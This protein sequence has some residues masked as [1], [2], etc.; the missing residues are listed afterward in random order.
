MVRGL[1]AMWGLAA[2][3]GPIELA[4]SELV[5][6]AIMHG[7]GL[8]DVRLAVAGDLIRLE[9]AD[10]GGGPSAPRRSRR[11]P[12]EFAGGWGLDLVERLSD[13]WGH[14]RDGGRT[15]VWMERRTGASLPGG[16]RA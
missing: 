3:Q 15:R 1:L 4:V 5:T 12:S 13:A 7:C 9:V 16:D 8:I 10:Q 11:Q 2:E 14:S 6:N